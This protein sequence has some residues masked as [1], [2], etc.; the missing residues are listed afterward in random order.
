MVKLKK[1]T[2][3]TKT[4]TDDKK[5][6]KKAKIWSIVR[7]AIGAALI[8]LIVSVYLQSLPIVMVFIGA[9]L[10]V[11]GQVDLSPE[12]LMLWGGTAFG[13]ILLTLYGMHYLFKKIYKSLVKK[14]INS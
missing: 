1:E 4:V 9:Y 11:D 13:V 2:V 8:A 3:V 6:S 7:P 14:K 5:Q 12:D 10:G